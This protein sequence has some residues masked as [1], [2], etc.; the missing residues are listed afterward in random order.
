MGLLQRLVCDL[1]SIMSCF[2]RLVFLPQQLVLLAQGEK[3]RL[4]PPDLNV[5][6]ALLGFYLLVLFAKRSRIRLNSAISI[7][8]QSRLVPG[9]CGISR[10]FW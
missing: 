6:F 7:G 8:T 4:Q 2:F 5:R 1:Q 3:L 9:W 10:T